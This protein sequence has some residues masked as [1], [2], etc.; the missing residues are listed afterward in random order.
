MF[1]R[2]A[3]KDDLTCGDGLEALVDEVYSIVEELKEQPAQRK[4]LL[5]LFDLAS[6]VSEW[7]YDG[8]LTADLRGKCAAI[9]FSWMNEISS[10]TDNKLKRFL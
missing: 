1:L 3:L 9:P 2:L 7:D 8:D 6:F 4:S 10:S 5:L